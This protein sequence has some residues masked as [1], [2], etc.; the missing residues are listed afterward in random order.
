ML[1]FSKTALGLTLLTGI[2][3]TAAPVAHAQQL[4]LGREFP[5]AN[6]TG[7]LTD[8]GTT[9]SG[10]YNYSAGTTKKPLSSQNDYDAWLVY[11]SSTANV[12][13]GSIFNLSAVDSSTAN[14][15][16]GKITD[17]LVTNGTSTANVS[18]GRLESLVSRGNSTVNFSGGS[19]HLY[20]LTEDSSTADISG[21]TM[22][23]LDTTGT[24]TA[25]VSGGG[26]GY[27]SITDNSEANVT[28]GVISSYFATYSSGVLNLFGT[29]LTETFLTKGGGYK[30]YQLAGTLQ[31]GDLLNAPYYDYGGTI[32][33]YPSA[34]VPEASSVVS[35]GLLLVLGLGGIVINRRCKAGAARFREGYRSRLK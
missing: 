3:L 11:A 12:S 8:T 14:V 29:G 7:T 17:A 19:I 4:N 16:G 13:G 31:N 22:G 2:A 34:A 28:G 27:I 21:G 18:G 30:E 5:A 23:A 20:L 6:G 9:A 1:S 32:N 35:L 15:S 10:L 33:L 25:N 24:S 26:F